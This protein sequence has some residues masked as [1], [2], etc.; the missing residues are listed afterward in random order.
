MQFDGQ[1]AM[2]NRQLSEALH[3]Y[4]MGRVD[5]AKAIYDRLTS[6]APQRVEPYL[7]MG[8]IFFAEGQHEEALSWFERA[9]TT[10]PGLPQALAGAGQTLLALGRP[11]EAMSVFERLLRLNSRSDM[12]LHGM[13]EALS[14]LG[15]M[16]EARAAFE[17]A[18]AL[19]PDVVGH[20]CALAY[21][22]R[23]VENDP[24]L[25][26]LEN[27]A[28]KMVFL[29]PPA[30]CEL[31]FA[32][33]R[34]CD[35]LGRHKQA[36]AHWQAGNALKRSHVDYDEGINL[37]ILEDLAAAFPAEVMTARRGAGDPSDIPVF[38]VGMP[39]SGTTLV[40]QIVASHPQAHGAG[41]LKDLHHLLSQNVLGENFPTHF[42]DMPNEALQ[43][44]GSLYV[45]RLKAMAP[46]ADRVIDKLP[47][48]FMLCGLIHLALPAARIIH[49][50]RDPVDTCFSCYANL[51][52]Q[53]IY[54]SYDLGELGRYYRAYE[55]LMDHWRDVLPQGAML[56]V[57]YEDLVANFET[58]ARRIIAYCGL[59]WDARCLS[60]HKTERVVH[61][62][63]AA[64]VRL[65]L[66]QSSIGRAAPYRQWLAPLIDALGE[67][68]D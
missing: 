23:F 61:T 32:L 12:A 43:R 6:L 55:A 57:Q 42:A 1:N 25:T 50:R 53:G 34:A 51:F 44:L 38:V 27:L 11:A 47:S 20:H 28:A 39:R 9:C 13:G 3:L 15:R 18:V 14:Q 22:G 37:G 35:D 2:V 67:T 62:L 36:F 40:E 65:P 48:N 64:Q 58:E 30:Q 16:A 60:F 17:R 29:P 63:S 5:E 45:S 68:A 46:R 66:Y 4:E 52:S 10:R 26:G 41:E 31:H 56:E 19:A 7:N 54:Y 8:E 24:R 59:D 33:A 49:V 21:V